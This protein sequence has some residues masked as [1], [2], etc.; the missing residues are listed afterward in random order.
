MFNNVSKEQLLRQGEQLKSPAPEVFALY[1]FCGAKYIL[2]QQPQSE[3]IH[4]IETIKFDGL[5]I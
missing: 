1:E 5:N 3:P 4:I 2:L